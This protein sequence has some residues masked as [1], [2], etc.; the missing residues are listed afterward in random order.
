MRPKTRCS[1]RPG[2]LLAA[3]L[4]GLFLA[5]CSAVGT[6]GLSRPEAPEAYRRTIVL[7]L[8]RP[9]FRPLGGVEVS[10]ETEAPTRLLQ[11]AGGRGRTDGRGGLE[12]VFE[13]LPHYDQSVWAGG[14]IIVDYPIKA[15]LLIERPGRGALEVVLDDR[16]SFARYADPLYQ[17]LNRD[18]ETG[19]T[20]YTV[21][22]P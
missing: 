3:A 5:G 21:T 18:P 6:E 9:D 20:Y 12:L 11:P 2:A 1:P 19:L 15:R 8:E 14:D 13:P 17:G 16:E 10:I 7:V 22:V 4:L